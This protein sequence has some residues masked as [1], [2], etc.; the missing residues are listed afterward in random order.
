MWKHKRWRAGRPPLERE[1][2]IAEVRAHL[3]DLMIRLQA[4]DG[5]LRA[6]AGAHAEDTTPSE[7]GT[8]GE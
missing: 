1:Q 2:E 7:E 4:F 3:A 6:Y 8:P 5:R